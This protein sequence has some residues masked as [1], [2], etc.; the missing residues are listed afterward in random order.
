MT[1]NKLSNTNVKA[2]NMV[3]LMCVYNKR[4]FIFGTIKSSII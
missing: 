3:E 1:P 4:I 2:V